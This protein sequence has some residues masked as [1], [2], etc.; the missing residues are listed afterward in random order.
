[1]SRRAFLR[2]A[3]MVPVVAGSAMAFPSEVR[4]RP[5]AARI[6]SW[7]PK[8]KAV[9]LS[10][11]RIAGAKGYQVRLYN[12][13]KLAKV[14]KSE[15]FKDTSGMVGGLKGASFYYARVRAYRLVHGKRVYGAWSSKKLVRTAASIEIKQEYPSLRVF[16]TGPT[17]AG[18]YVE[19]YLKA[20]CL[21]LHGHEMGYANGMMWITCLDSH[22]VMGD[23]PY[24]EGFLALVSHGGSIYLGDSQSNWGNTGQSY[25]KKKRL[26][27]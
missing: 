5:M 20:R 8:A 26:I 12:N 16:E 3:L 4:A 25:R 18:D 23:G 17:N 13:V 15:S 27:K 6:T 10:W 9:R 1:M 2:T 21:P 11:K 14:V 24:M 22:W 7:S 19:R